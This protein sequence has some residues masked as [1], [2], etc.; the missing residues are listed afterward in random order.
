MKSLMPRQ[1]A[2]LSIILTLMLSFSCSEDPEAVPQS[3]EVTLVFDHVVGNFPLSLEDLEYTNANGDGFRVSKFQYY[4]SNLVFRKADGTEYHQPESYYLVDESIPS[5]K[6]VS[7]KDVPPGDYSGLSFTI[8][9]DSA[10]NVAGAQTGALDPANGMFWSWNTGYVFLKLEGTS[11]QSKNGGLVFHTG[12]FQAP[13]NSLRTVSLPFLAGQK[14]R[15]EASR[16]PRVSLS[17]DVLRLFQGV[18]TI[19]FSELS[20]TMGG[21]NSVKVADNYTR[22]FTV[23]HMRE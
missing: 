1:A 22:M 21:A 23:G 4:I 9:V 15:V 20:S 12:G 17:A 2:L 10:R 7:V 13:H 3:G 5:S 8:G 6:L 14:L 11:P 19:R 18:N 16:T